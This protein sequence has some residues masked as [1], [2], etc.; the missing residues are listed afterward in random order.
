MYIH[1]IAVS[2][3]DGQSLVYHFASSDPARVLAKRRALR[4]NTPVALAEYGVHVLKTDRAD[5]TSVQA[6]DPYFSGAKLYTD[7]APFFSALAPLVQAALAERR[8]RFGWSNAADT[9]S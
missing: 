2:K 9:D 7:F 3:F 5:F 4:E 1:L 8:A 6:L